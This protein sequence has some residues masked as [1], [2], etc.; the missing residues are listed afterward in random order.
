MNYWI[1]HIFNF[2]TFQYPI[3]GLFFIIK[4]RKLN[5]TRGASKIPKI[6]ESLDR[7]K[8]GEPPVTNTRSHDLI[9]SDLIYI[10]VI[11][12]TFT[13]SSTQTRFCFLFARCKEQR[14]WLWRRCRGSSKAHCLTEISTRRL[15]ASPSLPIHIPKALS[16]RTMIFSYPKCP[17]SITL[18]HPILAH[19]QLRSR[20]SARSTSALP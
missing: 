4:Q 11:L 3:H 6:I 16:K 14:F 7:D 13:G 1:W 20:R 15:A 12:S 10:S 17:T 8:S 19:L 5:S 18:H 2:Q 9:S